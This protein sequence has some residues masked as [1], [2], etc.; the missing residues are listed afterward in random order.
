[1]VSTELF[2][3][4]DMDRQTQSTRG[5]AKIWHLDGMTN[6]RGYEHDAISN[7]TGYLAAKA[8]QSRDSPMYCS[9]NLLSPGYIM[10]QG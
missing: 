5:Y 3:Y 7:L 10:G 1:M 8:R 6:R 4:D 2:C 9:T